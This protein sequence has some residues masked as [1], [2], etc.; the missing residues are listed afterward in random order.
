MLDPSAPV[1][2]HNVHTNKPPF[3]SGQVIQGF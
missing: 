1:Q 3:I 2:I